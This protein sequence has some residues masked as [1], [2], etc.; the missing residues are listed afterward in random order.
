M[1]RL[2]TLGTMASAEWIRSV[3][4]SLTPAGL[5]PAVEFLSRLPKPLKSAHTRGTSRIAA[6]GVAAVPGAQISL[7]KDVNSP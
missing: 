5:L 2:V 1:P 7:S 4:T 6:P 3:P